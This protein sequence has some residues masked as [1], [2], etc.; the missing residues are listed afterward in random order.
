MP[1]KKTSE[2]SKESKHLQLINQMPAGYALHEMIYNDKGEPVDYRFLEVNPAFEKLTGL[3]AKDI[4]GRACLEVLPK[5]ESSWIERY[6]KVALTG[7]SISFED[8]SQEIDRHFEVTAFRTSP[9]HFA[10]TF[11]DITSHKKAEELLRKS[12]EKTRNLI[13]KMMNAFVLHELIYDEKGEAFDYRFLEVNPA[14][15]KITGI[16]SEMVIGKTI[17]EFMPEIEDL[18]IDKY[19]S[20]VETGVPEEFEKY[21]PTTKTYFYCYAYRTEPGKFAIFFND[22]T[23]R[24]HSE[25]ALAAEKERLAVTLRSIG[26]GVITTDTK[27]NIVMLNKAAEALTGWNS[28]EA[29]GHPLPDVF[30]IINENTRKQCENPVE[31]VL[32]TGG[33]VELANHTCLI[34]KD[35]Q[36]IVI[37]DSGAPIHDNNS[38]IIGVVLVFRDMTEKQKLEDSMQ[39]A[40]K[41]ESLGVLAG[42]IAHD[43]NNILSAIF[44]YTEM[45]IMISK[46]NDIS[47]Y[48]NNSLSNIGRAR[49]LT[50]QLLTFAKGGAPIKKVEKLFPFIKETVQFALSGSS[51]SSKF[52]IP[53]NLWSCDLDKNQIGQV[54]DNLTINAQQAM[55][56]GGIIEVSAQ[57]ISLSE[58]EHPSL[59]A[60]NYVKLSIID[61]GIGIPKEFLPRIFDP[62]YTTKAK[63]HGLGL[64]TCYSIINRHEG[65]IDV[66]SDLGNGSTFH[67]YLPATI[68]SI[69]TIDKK[70][71]KR[72]S[73]SGTFLVMDDDKIILALMKKMLESLGYDVVLKTNGADAVDFFTAEFK[74]GRKIAGMIFDLTIPGGMGGK[75]AIKE[76]RKLCMDT[77]V[78][79]SSGYSEDPIISNP[80]EYGFNASISKPFMISDL[81]EML[82]KHLRKVEV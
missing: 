56:N 66:E 67:I 34:A 11:H 73:G 37:A 65:Y 23:D 6:G 19:C 31:R 15:E 82:E 63:G 77:P 28:D 29:S 44:G 4:V 54:I 12:E 75:E 13:A 42:G 53:E 3:K 49:A 2:L 18:W 7:E 80:E 8:F 9:N 30:N 43:F 60:G 74:A 78:F 76:I 27:G 16:K 35:G 20:V 50:Q 72:H 57:N 24:K 39:R 51:V 32:S 79:V 25:L 46:E 5:T 36:E 38:K 62:Y 68:D 33:I 64:A 26:D 71:T 55:P 70:S 14:W 48:L 58:N 52:D 61:Q 45:A 59:N 40:Q 81:S 1:D 17:R 69:L 21:S 10:C 22:I 47:D 41:L